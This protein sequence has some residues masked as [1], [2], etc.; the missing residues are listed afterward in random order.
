MK[1]S[2]SSFDSVVGVVTWTLKVGGVLTFVGIG[3][4]IAGIISNDSIG[5]FYMIGVFAFCLGPSLIFMPF[6]Y[7][8]LSGHKLT[9][10]GV[11]ERL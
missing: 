10:D 9:M 2:K 4:I 5:P 1:R 6:L 8:F 7:D 3:L 11:F